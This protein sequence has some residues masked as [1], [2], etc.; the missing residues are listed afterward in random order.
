MGKRF[1]NEVNLSEESEEERKQEGINHH[2]G[3]CPMQSSVYMYLATLKKQ[4]L[5]V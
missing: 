2:H 4:V 5:N 3:R 1:V